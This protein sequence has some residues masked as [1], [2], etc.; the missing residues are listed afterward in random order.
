[1]GRAT[2]WF[3]RAWRLV[4]REERDCVSLGSRNSPFLKLGDWVGP[5]LIAGVVILLV[6]QARALGFPGVNCRPRSSW[7]AIQAVGTRC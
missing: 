1:M 3:G 5:F 7:L 6:T 2:G 4:E